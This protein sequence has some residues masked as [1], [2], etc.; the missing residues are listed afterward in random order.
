MAEKKMHHHWKLWISIFL[1]IGI[2]S[3]LFYT[4]AGKKT[5]GIFKIGRFVDTYPSGEKGFSVELDTNEEAFYSQSYEVSNTTFVASGICREN[6]KMDNIKINRDGFV[7][8]I[9]LNSLYGVVDYTQGGSVVISGKAA[10]MRMDGVLYSGENMKVMVEVTPNSFMLTDVS[11]KRIILQ[12]VNGKISKLRADG[13][14]SMVG[15]LNANSLK[16]NNFNGDIKLEEN[17]LILKGTTDSVESEEFK[18]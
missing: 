15:F 14:V 10:S 2:M 13:N 8:E 16:I 12:S 6:I 3:L 11:E 7:C 17:H 5:L 1:V 18:W 9:T 4:D